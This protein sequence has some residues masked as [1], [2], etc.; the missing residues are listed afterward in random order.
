[1][2][3][4]YMS[5]VA[6]SAQNGLG[7]HYTGHNA[8]AACQSVRSI[9]SNEHKSKSL[10]AGEVFSIILIGCGLRREYNLYVNRAFQTDPPFVTNELRFIL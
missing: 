4:G 5:Q 7:I 6:L 1:M 8:D 9:A 2:L 3:L 10:R